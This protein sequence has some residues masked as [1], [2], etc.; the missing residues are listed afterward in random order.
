MTFVQN[1]HL[2][3]IKRERFYELPLPSRIEGQVPIHQAVIHGFLEIIEYLIIQVC[4]YFKF[5]FIL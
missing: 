3:L 5:I 1:N 4:N 2:F